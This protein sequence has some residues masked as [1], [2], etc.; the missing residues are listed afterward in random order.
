M[1]T[2]YWAIDYIPLYSTAFPAAILRSL[3]AVGYCPLHVGS[4]TDFRRHTEYSAWFGNLHSSSWLVGS[5][6]LKRKAK[7]D[8]GDA[9]LKC[10]PLK[11]R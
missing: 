9:P 7:L 1:T 5:L 8:S 6:L 2:S 11:L 3:L 10:N 4:K